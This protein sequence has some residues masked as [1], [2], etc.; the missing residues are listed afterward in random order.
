MAKACEVGI[1]WL[2]L[3]STLLDRH[4][5]LAALIQSSYNCAGQIARAESEV[6]VLRRLHSCWL[7]ASLAGPVGQHVDFALIK[8]KVLRSKPPCANAIAF[9]YSFMLKTCGGTSA[10]ILLETEQFLKDMMATTKSVGA[11]MFDVLST[12]MKNSGSQCIYLRHGLL[13]LA[14]CSS[15][16]TSET[17]R[18]LAKDNLDKC[19]EAESIMVDMRGVCAKFLD[20]RD[21]RMAIGQLDIDL[22][23]KVIG[24]RNSSFALIAHKF[25]QE[26]NKLT[27]SVIASRFEA[28]CLQ[29]LQDEKQRAAVPSTTL[30]SKGP[31]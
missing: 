3:P 12:D 17:K 31:V 4:R 22:A 21:V 9:M 2:V 1:L 5:G 7:A 23:A 16:S 24:K 20:R 6:Q 28:A 8:Q 27:G 29:E 13:K 18:F 11:E 25:I 19:L 10:S 30:H 15:V 26:L 14:Y